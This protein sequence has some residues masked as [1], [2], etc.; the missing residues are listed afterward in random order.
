[1]FEPK[2]LPGGAAILYCAECIRTRN[3]EPL[4]A[5][6]IYS[7]SAL[8]P[9]HLT[10]HTKFQFLASEGANYSHLKVS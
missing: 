4:Q 1:M 7:G 3:P 8:C 6:T 2:R 10:A 5:V 9:I